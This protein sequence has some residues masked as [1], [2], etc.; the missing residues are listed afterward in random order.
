MQDQ[1]S[2]LAEKLVVWMQE[3]IPQAQQLSLV[4]FSTPEAGASNETILFTANWE[5]QGQARTQVFVIRLLPKGEAVFPSYD[6]ALQYK[7]MQLLENTPIKVPALLA[8]E[9]DTA[10]FDS[11]FYVMFGIEGKVVAEQPPY[12]MDGWFTQIDDAA[13][14]ALWLNG[15]QTIAAINK[16]D[17]QA[18]GFDFLK[19]ENEKTPLQ[20]QMDEYKTFLQWTENKGQAY[21]A[22]WAMHAWLLQHQPENEPTALCWGDAKVANLLYQDNTVTAV[23]DWEM[24]HLGNPVDDLAWWM[25]LDNSMSEGLERLVGMAV[26]KQ[27]GLPC[28]QEMINLWEAASGFSAKDLDYYEVFAA[29][30]FGIIMTSISINLTKAGIMPADMHMDIN[31]TCTPLMDRLMKKHGIISTKSTQA[32][33]ATCA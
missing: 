15:I 10:L 14:N 20:Q 4:D 2:V 3:K 13:R 21:P 11:P 12:H 33:N 9:K 29:F 19:P 24:V 25:T 16:L 31:H 7:T 28:K 6:L 22:L 8:Y 18:L 5:E 32:S 17:W 27:T 1:H 23:L 26:P 30:K